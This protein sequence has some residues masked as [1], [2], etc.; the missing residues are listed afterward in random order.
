MSNAITI[1][2]RHLTIDRLNNITQVDND[3]VVIKP[4]FNTT[5]LTELKVYII[6]GVSL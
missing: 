4:R 2:G 3:T 6:K 5:G 1:F